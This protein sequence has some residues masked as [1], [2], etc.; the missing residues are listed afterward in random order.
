MRKI[1]VII[2]CYNVASYVDRCITSIVVQTIGIDN[3][4]IIC[5]DDASTDHTW[6]HLQKWEQKFPENILLIRQEVNRRQGAARN[7]GLQ[8]ASADWVAFVDADDWLEPDY[9]EQLYAPVT[10]FE[11]DVVSCDWRRD[12]SSSL[13]Y[14]DEEQR[15]GGKGQYIIANTKEFKKLL[16]IH[17]CIEDT[18]VWGKLIRKSLIMENQLYF[19][20]KLA[21]EDMYWRPLLDIYATG[22]YRTGK[23]LYHYFLNSQSVSLFI[24]AE[25]HIDWIT[26]QIEKWKEYHNR[27]IWKEYPDE[28]EFMFLADA[29]AFFKMLVLRY[30]EPSF[31]L[32]QLE[33]NLI[34]QYVPDYRNNKYIS[35]ISEIE[36]QAILLRTLYSNPSKKEF[37]DIVETVKNIYKS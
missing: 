21:Y 16:L 32:F 35:V 3:L 8:Y 26:I 34:R 19:P 29:V 10:Q 33:K 22:I 2:P 31:S 28:M 18:V 20:E 7:V 37:Q 17:N 12:V 6:E 13:I 4:E 15:R 30:E 24:N 1:S 9:F 23:K 36:Q 14:F 11:C 5:I 25:H 27:G